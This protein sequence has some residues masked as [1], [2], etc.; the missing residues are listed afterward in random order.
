MKASTLASKSV[1]RI[2]Q[3]IL[4]QEEKLKKLMAAPT[5]DGITFEESG[6]DYLVIDEAHKCRNLGV[7]TTV[8]DLKKESSREAA[9]LEGR[10][11]VVGARAVSFGAVGRMMG[12]GPASAATTA[13]AREWA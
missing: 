10:I 1:K 4:N 7:A 13:A 5:D 2:E 12:A 6:I 8:D 11:Q 9:L 3:S